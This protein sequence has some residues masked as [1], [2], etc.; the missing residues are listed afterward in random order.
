M[1]H[2]LAKCIISGNF[3]NDSKFVHDLTSACLPKLLQSH[4]KFCKVKPF[5][6]VH[7]VNL[8]KVAYDIFQTTPNSI[9]IQGRKE[10][11]DTAKGL[12]ESSTLGGEND[13]LLLSAKPFGTWTQQ[14]LGTLW[15]SP[16]CPHIL[17]LVSIPNRNN[18][19]I[20][21]FGHD[22]IIIL[23]CIY[24][25]ILTF[26]R[27]CSHVSFHVILTLFMQYPTVQGED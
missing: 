17:H 21:G 6:R 1:S 14:D 27:V 3:A 24:I 9:P 11:T 10:V 18:P 12:A 2:N 23:T 13:E 25:L 7:L 5:W 19:P 20:H 16:G 4:R 22:K 15:P 26:F 8:F